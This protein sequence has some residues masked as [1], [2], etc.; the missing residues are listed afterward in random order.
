MSGWLHASVFFDHVRVPAENLVGS[1]DQGWRALMAAIDYERASLA[2]PGLV[3]KQLDR[4]LAY[5]HTADP[6]GRRPLDD[7]AVRDE[8][9]TLAVEAEASRLYSYELARRQARGERP[10]HETSLAVL[11]KRETARLADRMGVQL[12][13]PAA[14]L[15][16]GSPHAVA[17]GAIEYG[18]RD[19]TYFS[20]AAGGF[21][22]TRNVLATR[23]LRL[24]REKGA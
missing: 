17:D 3:D 23:G 16:K 15:R 10:D 11:L 5:V 1:L 20:F 12:L 2:A 19:H 9:V 22:I 7:A 21:D 18:F 4:L 8:L 6:G 13:G 14:Q 24:P